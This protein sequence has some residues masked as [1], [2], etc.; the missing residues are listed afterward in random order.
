LREV[1]DMLSVQPG[2]IQLGLQGDHFYGLS[3]SVSLCAA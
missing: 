3:V 2:L 1:E